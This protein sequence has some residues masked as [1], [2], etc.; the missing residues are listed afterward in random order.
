MDNKKEMK[1]ETKND[2][3]EKNII[4]NKKDNAENNQNLEN[5]EDKKIEEK[6]INNKN[7]NNEKENIEKKEEKQKIKPITNLSSLSLD[8][9][10]LSYIKEYK[11]F[12]CGL[13]PSPETAYDIICCGTLSCEECIKKMSEDTKV[14]PICKTPEMKNRKIKDKN[15][16]FYKIYKNLN[17]KCPYKCEWKGA[18]MELDNHLYECK[19]SIRYCKYKS[20]GCEFFNDNQSVL[21]H[22]KNNDKVHLEM[23]LKYI[24]DNNIKKKKLKFVIGDKCRVSCHPHEMVY[25]TTL[26]W[27][28]DGRKLPN[29]CYSE[30]Y[31]FNYSVPRY[32]C[33]SCDFD[34]CDKCIVHYVI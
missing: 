18:W 5:G 33:N 24:K 8:L 23:A 14:C 34:L 11:C 30:D 26:P 19:L 16:V 1:L 3:N 2:K 17:I 6:D 7:S 28:C 9:F 25:M 15:K 13:I 22:E 12:L 29:G 20:I 32:R 27:N 31:S 4:E 21:E 10:S